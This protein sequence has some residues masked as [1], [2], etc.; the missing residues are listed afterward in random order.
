MHHCFNLFNFILIVFAEQKLGYLLFVFSFLHCNV[1][2][3]PAIL[4][5]I[6]LVP[7]RVPVHRSAKKFILRCPLV[8][9]QYG[10]PS[11]LHW[12]VE[13][14][15][16][17]SFPPAPILYQSE[18][19]MTYLKCKAVHLL[20][21]LDFWQDQLVQEKKKNSLAQKSKKV[22]SNWSVGWGGL[23][24]DLKNKGMEIQ[25]LPSSPSLTDISF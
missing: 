17:P 8:P 11:P 3:T 9:P 10:S 4:L 24:L 22:L 19:T 21:F 25:M 18:A 1:R 2:F 7:R 16:M 5:L 13:K 20:V 23:Q 12:F 15:W 6:P 14:A